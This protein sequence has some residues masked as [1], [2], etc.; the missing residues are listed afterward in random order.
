[1]L[2]RNINRVAKKRAHTDILLMLLQMNDKL[3][4][5]YEIFVKYN[6]ILALSEAS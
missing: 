6:K 5:A 1:M 2:F 3:I 4:Y